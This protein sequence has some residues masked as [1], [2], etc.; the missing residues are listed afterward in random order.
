MY[1]TEDSLH[2]KGNDKALVKC[3]VATDI[4]PGSIVE[5]KGFQDFLKVIDPKY[6]PPSCC[7]IMRDHF[8]GL[9]KNTTEKLH[10]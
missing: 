7:T 1:F 2:H 10:T 8:P 6:I 4:Q 5:D 9:Y 3:Y